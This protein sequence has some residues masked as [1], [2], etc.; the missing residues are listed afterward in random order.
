MKTYPRIEEIIRWNAMTTGMILETNISDLPD[1][2]YYVTQLQGE[3]SSKLKAV[4]IRVTTKIPD[5]KKILVQR[6]LEIFY[7]S[8]RYEANIQYTN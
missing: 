4:N 7:P 1:Q 2:I 5:D 8:T 6:E 3:N